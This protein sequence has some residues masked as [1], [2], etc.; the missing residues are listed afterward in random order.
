MKRCLAGN[1]A[2]VNV[3]RIEASKNDI[4]ASHHVFIFA[5]KQTRVFNGGIGQCLPAC[6]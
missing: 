3:F 6:G 5:I 4:E 2:Q 1:G